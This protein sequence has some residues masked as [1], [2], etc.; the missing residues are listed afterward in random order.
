MLKNFANAVR[1]VHDNFVLVL[2]LG[3]AEMFRQWANIDFVWIISTTAVIA[4][5]PAV[6]GRMTYALQGNPYSSLKDILKKHAWNYYAVMLCINVPLYMLIGILSIPLTIQEHLAGIGSTL[7]FTLW[8]FVQI[9][10][11]YII[12]LVFLKRQNIPAIPAGL[13][14]LRGN[15]KKSMPLILLVLLYPSLQF[16]LPFMLPSTINEST[17]AYHAYSYV[18]SF[19]IVYVDLVIFALAAILLIPALNG[20]ATTQEIPA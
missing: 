1:L 9:L 11:V 7:Y 18:Y 13:K 4:L 12:P 19:T 17:F 20:K 2:I 14:Y 8:T 6:Y 5:V 10:L 15:I 3:F 16:G